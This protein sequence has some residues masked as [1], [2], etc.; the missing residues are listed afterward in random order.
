MSFAGAEARIPLPFETKKYDDTPLQSEN[1][2]ERK[3]NE[4]SR[5]MYSLNKISKCLQQ[6]ALRS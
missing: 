1:I 5:H 4:N 6:I 2:I 3:S